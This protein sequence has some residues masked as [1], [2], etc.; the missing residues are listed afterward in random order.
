MILFN[1]N[2]FQK[3]SL[4]LSV[5][6]ISKVISFVLLP[7]YLNL[8]PKNEF[9][10]YGFV[11]VTIITASTLMTLNFYIFIIKDLSV[12][13]KFIEQKEKFSTLFIFVMMCNLLLF[14]FGIAC[15]VY[16][17]I[18]SNFFG[19][20]LFQIEKVICILL[21]IF[22]NVASLFQYSLILSRK[23]IYEICLFILFKVIFANFF[24]LIF[25]T[26]INEIYDTVLLRLFGVLL[27]EI[28][29]FISLHIIINKNYYEINFNINYFNKKIL[30]ALPL[31]ASSL[32]SLIITVVDR[33]LLQLYYGNKYLAEYNLVYFLLL[34]ITMIVSSFQSIWNPKMF[35][36]KNYS[37]AFAKTKIVIIYMFF[38]LLFIA[39]SIYVCI[40]IL[41]KFSFINQE[42]QNILPLYLAMT[43]GFI[44]GILLNFIDGLNLYLNRTLYKL[45]VT[46]ITLFIFSV[47]NFFLIPK[48][49][50][51]GIAIS[52]FISNVVG[53]LIGIIL[54]YLN[55]KKK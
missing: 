24:S 55:Y 17:H 40:L 38:F 4:V 22:F 44:F 52:L 35:N 2:F 25:L 41:F 26:N 32:A 45:Y 30:T 48:Y 19:I 16:F 37:L 8:M 11:F 42:Y 36:I 14:F 53:F 27:G 18:I 3:I 29:Q 47:L 49:A 33:K 1:K 51:Y 15:E 31:I 39:A 10:E 21:L 28:I 20:L 46:L 12:I 43:V 34:P 23:K 5:D 54:L 6:V 13:K 7:I 9:G 50:Y